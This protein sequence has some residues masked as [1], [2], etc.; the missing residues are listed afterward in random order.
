MNI[1]Y[2]MK[3]KRIWIITLSFLLVPLYWLIQNFGRAQNN[4][5]SFD[6]SFVHPRGISI[7]RIEVP[8]VHPKSAGT[9]WHEVRKIINKTKKKGKTSQKSILILNWEEFHELLQ[10]MVIQNEYKGGYG[11]EPFK[12]EQI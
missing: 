2:K 4:G 9:V 6:G 5:S 12:S 3:Q 7:P 11:K 1:M 8:L 10:K